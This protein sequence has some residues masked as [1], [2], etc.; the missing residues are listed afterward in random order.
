[1]VASLQVLSGFAVSSGGLIRGD[2]ALAVMVDS[3]AAN[4]WGLGFAITSGGPFYGMK[5]MTGTGL[6]YVVASGAGRMSGVVHIPPGPYVRV[7]AGAA[8]VDNVVIVLQD[9]NRS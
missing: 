7:E 2:R 4:T 3:H 1:M 5:L 8:T 6:T 9:V